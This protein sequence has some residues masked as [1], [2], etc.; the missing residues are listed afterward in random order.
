MKTKQLLATIL[1]LLVLLPISAPL[2]ADEGS[3]S[4]PEIDIPYQKFVLD[5]GLTLIVHEDQG[6]VVSVSAAYH[7]DRVC[8]PSIS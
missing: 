3:A 8:L 4:L 6:S 5:N 7:G 2:R 1:T